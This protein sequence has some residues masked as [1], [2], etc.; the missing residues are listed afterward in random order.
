MTLFT[1][2]GVAL[3]AFGTAAAAAQH[4][5]IA[6]AV[7]APTAAPG[8]TVAPDCSTAVDTGPALQ[9]QTTTLPVGSE[10]FG[11]TA[12]PGY[13]LVAVG[14][15][16][17]VFSDSGATPRLVHKI[18]LPSG[19][20]AGATLSQ[21]GRYLL[22]AA[23]NGADV[24]DVAAAEHGSPHPML[25]QLE[26]KA[27]AGDGDGGAIEA[28]VST[29]D[30]YAFVSLEA[31]HSIAVYR[32]AAAVAG[33]FRGSY[34]V[35][36]IPTG[37]L[38]VG[39]AVSPDG[40]W[41]Y[42]TS[43]SAPGHGGD[44]VLSVIDIAKAERRPAHAVVATVAAGCSP[45]RVTTSADG[46][47]VWVTARESDELL[48]FSAAGLRGDP[49]DARLAAVRVGEA[50]VGLAVIDGGSRIVVAD[51]NRFGA[52]GESSGLTIVDTAAALEQQSAVLGTI[53]AGLF[54]R[55][56]AAEPN[57]SA[58]LVGNYESKTLEVVPL[59]GL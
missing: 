6:P 22:V 48:A 20:A 45:V 44:G 46:D 27:L 30:R 56:M 19:F 55:E 12:V 13:A 15:H 50:P 38:P 24:I 41:L 47:V 39:L 7:T 8:A 29:D 11:V 2:A 43:E 23:G 26:A 31:E 17:D 57:G 4:V 28:A 59:S 42:S 9:V 36:A 54:P 1:A 35:G 25:G 18:A 33:H 51:S 49:D 21:D 3:A 40:H 34:Y 32:L 58:L 14:N 53:P 52:R 16:A 5:S 37:A 10:P